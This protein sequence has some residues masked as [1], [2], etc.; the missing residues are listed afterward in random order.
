MVTTTTGPWGVE[1]RVKVMDFG[2]AVLE[3]R[4][5]LTA[6]DAVMGTIA[7]F[8]PE[9]ARGLRVDHRADIYAMGAVFYEMLTGQ[10]PFEATNPGEMIRHH[11]ETPAPSP[12]PAVNPNVPPTL[13][14]IVLVCM[15]KDP[16]DRYQ[17]VRSIREDLE[18]YRAQANLSAVHFWGSTGIVVSD[19]VG[20][21]SAAAMEGTSGDAD[22]GLRLSQTQVSS[23][24]PGEDE[25][26][27]HP[28]ASPLTPGMPSEVAR[29]LGPAGA[30]PP[31]PLLPSSGGGAPP[32]HP[33]TIGRPGRAARG[34]VAPFVRNDSEYSGFPW[35]PAP[36]AHRWQ[37]ASGCRK[38]RRRTASGAATRTSWRSCGRT[39]KPPVR[40]APSSTICGKCG[41]ENPT[42]G[43]TATSVGA[44]WRPSNAQ[45]AREVASH[46][47][48]GM[49]FLLQNNLTEA[50]YEFQQA[51]P[52]R[53]PVRGSPS[54]PG[55]G[56]GCAGGDMVKAEEELR[57][58]LSL[59]PDDFEGR[60]ELALLYRQLGKKSEAIGE[61]EESLRLRPDE[62]G[63][64]CQLAFLQAQRGNLVKAVDEYRTVLAYDARNLEAHLQLG[65]IFGSQGM[66]GDAVSEFE[67]GGSG[68]IR[69]NATAWQWLGRLNQKRNRLSEAERAFQAALSI[70]PS[71][72]RSMPSWALSTSPRSERTWLCACF[73][74]PS[75]STRGTSRRAVGW[76]A[77]T[78]STTSRPE[79]S[80]ELEEVAS[81]HP[82]DSRIHQQLGDLY[83][84][85][86]QV[87]RALG[88]LRADGLARS[89]QRRDAQPARAAVP[90][91]GLRLSLHPGVPEGPGHRSV[92]RGLPRGLGMASTRTG[93]RRPPCRKS[94]RR[95][96]WTRGM[97]TTSRRW[98]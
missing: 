13:E 15:R 67:A 4:H 93:P 43:S 39:M 48:L 98:A 60:R 31:A 61:F 78:S 6:A 26:H 50:V 36:G 16:A 24:R 95:P 75:R 25:L 96:S 49:R 71:D 2:L 12:R 7:Y 56:R 45:V 70:D 64:R 22:A 69:A 1:R 82:R 89:G 57:I 27:V 77:S 42:T 87:D 23:G 73:G 29:R 55:T 32:P 58:A 5:D 38:P 94:R 18:L 81:F 68:S 97:R 85:M 72:A 80:R 17:A 35:F 30:R 34:G 59:A 52:P 92:Q 37:V 3:D 10:L 54:E 88:R 51:P 66:V 8:A 21:G 28:L 11:M 47:E 91:E 74:R 83:L 86:N 90:E 19:P 79:P 9:Q 65:I 40:A 63:L 41:I 14:R 84:S 53:R 46:N 44:C 76:R 20:T 62:N 33:R